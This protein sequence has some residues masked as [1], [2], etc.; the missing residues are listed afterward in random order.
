VVTVDHLI[1]Q[2]ALDLIPYFLA[3]LLLVAE[4]VA[5][6]LELKMV[7]TVVQV[8]AVLMQALAEQAEQE[9]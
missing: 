8:V 7:V 2:E 3:L 1:L 6:A 5:L 4:L 9:Q